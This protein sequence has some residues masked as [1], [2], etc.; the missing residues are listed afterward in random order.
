VGATSYAIQA[1]IKSIVADASV[2]RK[3]QDEIDCVIAGNPKYSVRQLPNSVIKKMPFLQAC[4]LE[5]LR[6]YPPVFSQLRERVAPPE[7]I[8]LNGYAIPGGTY[9]GFNSIA[10]Q[11]NHIYGDDVEKYRPERWLIDDEVQLKRMRRD[12]DLV[13][14]H[15]NSKCLGINMANLELNKIV[16]EVCNICA[17]PK[18]RML[19]FRSSSGHTTSPSATKTNH[20]S[21][22]AISFL[23]TFA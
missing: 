1:I 22:E 7:G 14:G 23:R 9:V 8:V 10:S 2:V 5:G 12:L 13:F 18:S 21:R 6:I 11:L 16:F 20:G 4:I 15:G 19:I 17:L 3:L